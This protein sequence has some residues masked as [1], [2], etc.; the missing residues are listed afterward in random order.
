[1]GD[2]FD[3]EIKS[4][5][6][7]FYDY[8]HTA[9][10]EIF[11]RL[12]TIPKNHNLL[13]QLPTGGGKTIIFSEIAKR[14]IEEKKKKVLILT[15]RIELCKQTSSILDEF[16]V[17]NKVI[18]SKVKTL[19]DQDDF[20]CFVAMV[21]TLNN[22][23][24]EEMIEIH[25]IGLVIIDEAHYNSFR[26]LFSYLDKSHI[27]GV[28]ATPLSSSIKLPMNVNYDELIIG[29]SISSLISKGFLAKA[30]TFS[31][32]VDL[33]TL[34]I[35]INGDYTVSSS[36]RLYADYLMQEKLL[37]AY[38][39][40]S[41]GHKTLIFNSGINSS[42]A[43]YY[44]FKKAGYD[45]QHLDSTLNEVERTDILSWFKHTPNAILTSVG[46]LTTGFD[47]PTIKTIILNR[48]TKSLTLYHQM[49]GRGSR[50]LKDK[51]EFNVIDLGNNALRFGLWDM[52]I[53]WQEIFVSPYKYYQSLSSDFDIEKQFKYKMPENLR[54]KFSKSSGVEF[55][56][57]EAYK[58]CLT[59]GMRPIKAI[60]SSID[61]FSRIIFENSDDVFDAKLLI[62]EIE[63]AIDYQ[64]K[65]Y[66]Y[67][68]C[69]SSDS[70]LKW[71][72]EE[73]KRKLNSSLTQEFNK[74]EL[75]S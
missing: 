20:M 28:T 36:D 54:E 3:K 21:E 55:D 10:N 63:D 30:N 19:S 16:H 45:I 71:L 8:Q 5:E 29:N 58:G 37:H 25:D 49:I 44:M 27:L 15:H 50:I 39:A 56:I 48:A 51:K 66:S 70:Y 11:I 34:K 53:D 75:G 60:D 35:G 12:N 52:D 38:E 41:K 22:R 13:F 17:K 74:C 69:K 72:K 57:K 73:F 23:L 68:I 31:F 40:Q 7:E 64:V 1:M 26:K 47:E 59:V 46:I 32:D 14:F 61:F 4:V 43:V 42:K 24:K 6:K 65:Q 67:C 62:L 9:I 18:S 2:G 33:K